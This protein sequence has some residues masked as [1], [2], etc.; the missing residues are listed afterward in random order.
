MRKPAFK[1]IVLVIQLA[2]WVGGMGVIAQPIQRIGV[3]GAADSPMIKGAQLAARQINAAGG[4]KGPDGFAFQ[5]QVVDTPADNMDIAIANMSQARVLAALGP[6]SAPLAQRHL[7][8]LAGL[9]VPVFTAATDDALLW[10]DD[11]ERIFRS[12]SS[13]GEQA[14]ALADYVAGTLGARSVSF[15]QLDTSSLI[16]LAAFSQSLAS[17]G[18]ELSST[19]YDER[20][21]D[22]AT[23]AQTLLEMDP[24]V[25]AIVGPPG[26][27]GQ[28][29]RALRSAGFRGAFVYPQLRDPAFQDALGVSGAPVYT[30]DS[31]SIAQQNPGNREF[32]LAYAQTWREI[33]DEF[34]AA[35]YDA[36]MLIAEAHR[37][38]GD[39]AQSIAYKAGIDGAQ[40]SL[41]PYMLRAGETGRNAVIMRLDSDGRLQA[42]ARYDNGRQVEDSSHSRIARATPT[43]YPTPTPAPT[44]TP[45]GYHL[46]IQS[47][48]QN[49]R[50][51]PGTDYEVIGQVV[52]GAR[53]RVIGRSEDGRWLVIDFRGQFGWVA[54]WIVET[55]GTHNL[56]PVL[57][58][59]RSA[60][61]VPPPSAPVNPPAPQ[62]EA[63]IVVVSASPPRIT[64]GHASAVAVTVMNRGGSAAGFFSI[65]SALQP[66]NAYASADIHGL[67]AGQSATVHLYATVN[68][69]PGEQ[70]VVIVADLNNNVW[71]GEAGEANNHSFVYRYV[72]EYA[73]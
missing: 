9:G 38:G 58:A 42:A 57:P 71:E 67:G 3:I 48:Y 37:H 1:L 22:M 23:M 56:I 24:D 19:F 73:G 70:V 51:G 20:R 63:D 21:A 46:I 40:G 65:A 68:G 36:V 13:Q 31:W 41:T 55:F 62:N 60:T 47:R 12:R 26:Q 14:A 54:A 44:A 49:I 32:T 2:L 18:L 27:A 52:Q 11:S 50:S 5:L 53:L 10:N 43:P 64:I 17:R 34:A 45:E 69:A 35:A 39:L 59:P 29:A 15:V 72:A 16:W 33:P 7:S 25:V 8:Q 66:G 30:A 6:D 28:M 4:M 61:P